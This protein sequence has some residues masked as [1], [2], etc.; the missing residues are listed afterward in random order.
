MGHEYDEFGE[1]LEQIIEIEEPENPLLG[2]IKQV[3]GQGE[4]SLSEKQNFL[5]KKHV[6][7]VYTV[8]ECVLC[9]G[10]IPFSEMFD[11]ATDHGMCGHCSHMTGKDD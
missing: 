8:K 10:N 9:A 11:A 5:F 6:L 1:F 7:D 2:V 3:I 4:D